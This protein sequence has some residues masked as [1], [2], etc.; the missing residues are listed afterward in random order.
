MQANPPHD[1][2]GPCPEDS[3]AYHY[4][5]ELLRKEYK[6]VPCPFNSSNRVLVETDSEAA[7]HL[8]L[9]YPFILFDEPGPSTSGDAQ[10][11]LHGKRGLVFISGFKNRK[12]CEAAAGLSAETG[13]AHIRIYDATGY[14]RIE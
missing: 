9:T 10:Q 4:Y 13:R 6:I 14:V 1:E 5:Q 12:D 11:Q 2:K 7:V 8:T 3:Y